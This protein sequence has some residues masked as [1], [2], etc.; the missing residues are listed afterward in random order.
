MTLRDDIR[1]P[2]AHPGRIRSQD[3]GRRNPEEPCA[4]G[5]GKDAIG[6]DAARL[7]D[8][9]D[10]GGARPHHR[11]AGS[12]RPR[13]PTSTA[14]KR[15][16]Y[17]SLEFLIGRLM[18][19]AFSNLGLMDDMR[20]ALASL[21][22]DLDVIAA[23]EPD[24]ALGN[25]GLGRLAACFMES[26]ATVDVPAHGYGI[27]YVN[28]MFRQ[29]ISRRLAGRTAGDL[30]R[31]RQS[32]GVRAPRALLRGRLRRHGRIASPPR[33]GGSSAMSGSRTSGCWPSPTTRRSSAGAASASTRCGCGRRCRSIRSCST[34]STPATTSARCARATRP[35]RCRACSIRPIRHQAGQE[36]RLRQEY[37]FSAASLQDI[38]QRHL[39]QYGD[40][41][42]LPDKAAIHLNDTHPAV[43]VAELMRLLMDVHGI[44]FDKAWD[45]TKRHLRLH[46][47]HAAARG[48]GKLAGAAVRAAAA[49]PHADH[50]RHQ[51]RGPARGAR[52]RPLRRRADPPHLADPRRRRAPRAHGQPRLRR[53]ALDQRRVGAAHRADEGDGVRRPAQA[54]SRP[55]QQQDQR[56]HAAP[57]AD[58][59]QSRA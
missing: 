18:R 9:L 47:P 36:L 30:A 14:G 4:T 55:H 37:F 19:D 53:L 39:S 34:P 17:L 42:S 27:R 24:A 20:E 35:K 49:A 16:Y 8:R 1:T 28:G 46:Q 43:A 7:A 45:I 41:M 2:E 29:E 33:T 59:V 51:R 6:R 21:G 32:L 25:G 31:P 57:L 15:V 40:L 10:Q 26:M 54:L 12:T 3:P 23:L 56:H 38:L 48:A 52:D 13:K 44:D 50:L 22:V 58:P 11:P 5:V